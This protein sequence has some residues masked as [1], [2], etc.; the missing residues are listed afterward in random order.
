MGLNDIMARLQEPKNKLK[1]K[2]KRDKEIEHELRA[3]LLYLGFKAEDICHW[4]ID[5]DA[6]L[7]R[8][9]MT[10]KNKF[11][12]IIKYKSGERVMVSD[13]D[14]LQRLFNLMNYFL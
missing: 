11:K 14:S 9:M 4:L 10:N 6:L 7:M 12:M 3:S 8:V 1:S 5:T 2:P 13:I